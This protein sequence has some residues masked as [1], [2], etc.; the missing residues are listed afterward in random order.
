MREIIILFEVYPQMFYPDVPE[1]VRTDRIVATQNYETLTNGLSRAGVPFVARLEPHPHCR[2]FER[3]P[4]TRPWL[5]EN[6]RKY[7]KLNETK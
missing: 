6:L 5:Y 3:N 1:S 4:K 7:L 2:M